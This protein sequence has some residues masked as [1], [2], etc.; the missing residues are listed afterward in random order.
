MTE[1]A[2][3]KTSNFR[4]DETF[5]VLVQKALEKN[6]N[7]VVIFETK[8][9]LKDISIMLWSKKPESFLPHS[10][11]RDNLSNDSPIYLTT[12]EENPNKSQI[13]FSPE[14]ALVKKSKNWKRCI[15]IFDHDD[16]SS[17]DRLKE[18]Y[19]LLE[20]SKE[21]IELYEQKKGNWI[22][23]NFMR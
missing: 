10:I 22:K 23:N 3:Y 15:Y 1:F 7:S 9:A 2:F 19:F 14:G 11:E 17:F 13:I 18:Y 6:L 8:E 12:R 20:N 16:N 5:Y 21:K 4:V